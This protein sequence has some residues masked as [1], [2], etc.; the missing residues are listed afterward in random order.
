MLL[1][2]L[3]QHHVYKPC[4]LTM[5]WAS[6]IHFTPSHSSS[7]K[8]CLCLCLSNGLLLSFSWPKLCMHLSF[9]NACYIFCPS[10]PSWF[11]DPN[12]L[13]E[14]HTLI[15]YYLTNPS[16]RSLLG[17]NFFFSTLFSNTFNL[18]CSFKVKVCAFDMLLS[19][20][21]T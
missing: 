19:F 4:L 14:E 3:V 18:C 8:S 20:L 9:P 10:H 11:N 17:P 13:V 2:S 7:L 12:L 15:I 1:W 5:S 6:W 21:S 16:L